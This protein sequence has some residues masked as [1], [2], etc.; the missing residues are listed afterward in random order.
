MYF[1]RLEIM[2]NIYQHRALREGQSLD[3]IPNSLR[4]T[5]NAGENRRGR[6]FIANND[7]V[8]LISYKSSV[9]SFAD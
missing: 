1:F 6:E 2:Y 7:E 8:G 9:C 3:N 4:T 5:G